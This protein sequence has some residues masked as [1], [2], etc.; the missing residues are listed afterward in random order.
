MHL[1]AFLGVAASVVTTVHGH[2]SRA[3]AVARTDTTVD[4]PLE[5]FQVQAPL[6][7][8]YSGAACSKTIVQNDFTASYG[9]PYVG[10]SPGHPL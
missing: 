6:R 7:E 4:I 1:A 10:R 9:S 2:V 3:A 8:S 5:V